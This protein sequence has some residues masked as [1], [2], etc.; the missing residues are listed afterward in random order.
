MATR[1]VGATEFKAKCLAILD[2]VEQ[3]G[4][5]VT[6]TKRGRPVA[7]LQRAPKKRK[8]KSPLNSWKGRMEIVGDIVNTNFADLWEIAPRK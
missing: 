8:W 1:I 6:I 4:Q 3:H 7:V 2:E 5:P